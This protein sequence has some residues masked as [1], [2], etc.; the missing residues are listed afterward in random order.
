MSDEP[1]IQVG[2]TVRQL[3]AIL[4]AADEAASDSVLLR[5]T[6][7]TDPAS[8]EVWLFSEEAEGIVGMMEVDPEGDVTDLDE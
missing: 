2:I 3:G 1:L 7:A 4:Q 5:A 8:V 6:G